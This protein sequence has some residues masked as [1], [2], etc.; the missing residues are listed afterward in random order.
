MGRQGQWG[1]MLTLSDNFLT[2]WPIGTLSVWHFSQWAFTSTRW[3]YKNRHL[4]YSTSKYP[5]SMVSLHENNFERHVI[6]CHSF[7]AKREVNIAWEMYCVTS[8]LNNMKLS[9][10]KLCNKSPWKV[11]W[12]S[13][14]SM[15]NFLSWLTYTW[16]NIWCARIRKLF[17][18]HTLCVK[19][20]FCTL[21][22]QSSLA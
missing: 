11:V 13:Q 9:Y 2:S 21:W 17:L 6:L 20:V 12:F 10:N 22:K 3:R 15:N 5:P 8:Y 1:E 16:V 19:N 18:L 4:L 14:I 7:K